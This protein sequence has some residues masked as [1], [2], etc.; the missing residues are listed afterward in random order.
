MLVAIVGGHGQVARHLSRLLV[1][2]GHTARAI[3]R[4]PDHVD[5]VASDGAE[6]VV[7]DIEDPGSD[8]DAALAGADA[9]VFAAGAGPGSGA[10]R[11]GT[12]DLGGALRTIGSAEAT[13]VGRLVV[14]SAMGTDDPP[15]DDEVFSVYLRA[16]AD[17]DR[18]ALASSLAVTV[19]RPGAL[20][21]DAGTG[22]VT[23]DR[24]VPPGS[25]PRADVA[26][27]V[28]D[29]LDRPGT[30]GHVVEVVSGPT[31]VVEAVAGIPRLAGGGG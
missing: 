21:D 17:A 13:D 12:V 25:I 18:A 2:R 23:L 15:D 24:H 20:T 28:A 14:I 30:G 16:K 4:N 31:P 11:K 19:V 5:D 1:A 9:V 3:V 8:L 26:S 27:V 22:H 7:C 10:T 29:V 6:P